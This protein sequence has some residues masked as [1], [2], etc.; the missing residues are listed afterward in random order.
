MSFSRDTPWKWILDVCLMDGVFRFSIQRLVYYLLID[1]DVFRTYDLLPSERPRAF[2][3]Q[4]MYRPIKTCWLD[5]RSH[6][7][8]CLS[9]GQ[10]STA[11]FGI[12][13]VP[14]VM[15]ITEP[16]NHW[17]SASRP[18]RLISDPVNQASGTDRLY[19]RD[20]HH[21]RANSQPQTSRASGHFCNL[22]DP[23]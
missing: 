6:C 3:I 2:P 13:Q 17:I 5:H 15:V 19:T 9:V 10:C 20:N 16:R 18:P 4:E 11:I 21:Q 22:P 7:H 23:T 8:G 12:P 1:I 14:T